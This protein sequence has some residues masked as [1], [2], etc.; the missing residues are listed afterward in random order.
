MNELAVA[1]LAP[2]YGRHQVYNRHHS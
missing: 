2:E 1:Q